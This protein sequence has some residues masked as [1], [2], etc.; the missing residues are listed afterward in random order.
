[1]C[2]V[3]QY[4]INLKKRETIIKKIN[5][6]VVGNI[7]SELFFIPKKLAVENTIC[8][9]DRNYLYQLKLKERGK[10]IKQLNLQ[11]NYLK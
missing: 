6:I 3:F 11:K 9:F 8:L 5:N 2:A 4:E 1:M 10:S 7:N